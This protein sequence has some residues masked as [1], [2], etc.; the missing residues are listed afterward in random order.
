MSK[1]N[2]P[3]NNELK[4]NNQAINNDN[5]IRKHEVHRKNGTSL[6]YKGVEDEY[7]RAHHLGESGEKKDVASMANLNNELFDN[8]VITGTGSEI[9]FVSKHGPAKLYW[10]KHGTS[11]SENSM[12]M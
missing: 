2:V 8:G 12:Q 4:F 7:N 10:L 6:E 9:S 11:G 1:H 5:T 3:R